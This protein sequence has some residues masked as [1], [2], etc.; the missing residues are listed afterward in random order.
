MEPDGLASGKRKTLRA[1]FASRR[2][3]QTMINGKEMLKQVQNLVRDDKN[4]LAI[5][6]MLNLFQHLSISGS[7]YRFLPRF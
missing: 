2:H 4:L 1:W 7:R 3:W 6:V 5:D